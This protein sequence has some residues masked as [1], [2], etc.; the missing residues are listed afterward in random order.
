MPWSHRTRPG[1]V[2]ARGQG[3]LL[4]HVRHEAAQPGAPVFTPGTE[5][6]QIIPA[7]APNPYRRPTACIT[8][9]HANT[10]AGPSVTPGPG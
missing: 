4:I 10:I 1:R 8:A 3:G 9:R 7:V 5:G 6:V 2:A